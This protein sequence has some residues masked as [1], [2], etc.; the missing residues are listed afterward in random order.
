MSS[1]MEHGNTEEG[2]TPDHPSSGRLRRNRVRKP[3]WGEMAQG[4][5][6]NR[7][8]REAILFETAARLFNHY[9]FHGTS[10]S[11]LTN[12]LG[13]T[14][15]ALYH[16][17]RDKSDLLYQL[18]L[19]SAGATRAAF[20]QGVSGGPNGIERVRLVIR[21]YLETIARSPTET[22]IL[23][24]NKALHPEQAQEIRLLRRTLEHDLRRQIELGIADGTIAPQ[25]AKLATLVIVGAIAWVSKWYDPT[26]EWSVEE[27]ATGIS[28]LLARMIAKDQSNQVV[29]PASA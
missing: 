1:A 22:F 2:E 8:I 17:V 19:K 23:M 29:D 18:H 26:Q 5:E 4:R 21:Y 27:V 24:E 15:G 11:M 25:D 16:Y 13:L 6:E 20:E 3:A 12:E 28:A 14:K 10:M 7:E 9:G